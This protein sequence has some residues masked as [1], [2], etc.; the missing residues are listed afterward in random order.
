VRSREAPRPPE[1]QIGDLSGHTIKSNGSAPSEGEALETG[2]T[3][4]GAAAGGAAL[5]AGGVASGLK[6][7]IRIAGVLNNPVLFGGIDVDA[8]VCCGLTNCGV[9][10]MV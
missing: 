6:Y 8:T 10:S 2:G 4:P 7:A 3:V 9:I 1:I 5:S